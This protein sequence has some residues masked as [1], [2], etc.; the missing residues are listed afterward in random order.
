MFSFLKN[1]KEKKPIEDGFLGVYNVSL[2]YEEEPQFFTENIISKLKGG[3]GE[4]E[5]ILNEKTPNMI[6]LAFKEHCVTYKNNEVLP[7]QAL[8]TKGPFQYDINKLQVTIE[9]SKKFENVK[10]VVSKAK[11]QIVL[12]DMMAS[13]LGHIERLSLFQNLIIAL[14]EET[15]CIA[16]N[17]VPSGQFIEPK[18]YLDNIE[19]ENLYGA[20]N[21]RFFNIS[22]G[23]EGDFLIDTLG[24]AALGIPDLQC[25]FNGLPPNDMMNLI[26]NMAY[27]IYENGDVIQDGH[28]VEGLIQGDK[29]RCQHEIALAT[30]E[31]IVLDINPGEKFSAGNR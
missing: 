23:R 22:N 17:W 18:E 15:K 7:A 27:Y 3:C 1:K 10:E 29:W 16:I 31:R 21:V 14:L 30:P 26:Y 11:Y 13:G 28:T 5:S 6:G 24:L 20:V 19:E 2:L 8:I 25:H 9:Q 4:V 12:T